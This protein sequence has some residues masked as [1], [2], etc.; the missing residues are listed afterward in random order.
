M[1]GSCQGGGPQEGTQVV[2]SAGRQYIFSGKK[3][4]K[5]PSAS[6]CRLNVALE[7]D[8]GPSVLSPS[9]LFRFSL[10]FENA[11]HAKNYFHNKTPITLQGR[12]QG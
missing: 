12:G 5:G 3:E 2:E 8:R 1:G 7:E 11:P 10:T 4:K 9:P 6:A